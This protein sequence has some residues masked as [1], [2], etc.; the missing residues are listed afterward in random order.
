M[1]HI[2]RIVE[3]FSS[4]TDDLSHA[5]VKNEKM[6]QQIIA[7][8]WMFK[9]LRLKCCPICRRRLINQGKRTQNGGNNAQRL[10]KLYC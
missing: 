10:N 4:A 2:N 7:Q 9:A 3:N 5:I 8:R 1:A 6:L